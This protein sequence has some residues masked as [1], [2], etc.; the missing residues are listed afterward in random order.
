MG[1]A[2][3]IV[4]I[5]MAALLGGLIAQALKQPL[6]LGYILAGIAVGPYTGGITV[7]DIHN[8][9][10]LAEIGIALLLFALGLEFSF[11]ELRPVRAIALFGTPLQIILTILYGFA[12]GQWLGWSWSAS[13]W[14]GAL[15]SLSSTMVMIKTLE[16]QGMMGTLSSRVMIGVLIVQDL[17]VVPMLIILPQLNNIANGFSILLIAAVK[18]AVFLLTMILIGTK[19]I[20]RLM[21]YIAN[22]NSRELFLITTTTI[23]LGIGYGTYIFGLSFAFGAFVAGILLSESDY[24]YQALSDI[25]PLRD[26]FSLLFFTSIGMLLDINFL[27][28]NWQM[29]V[30][31]VM[32][33]MLGKAVIFAALSRSFGY[34]NVIPLAM[35]L[36]L[37][38]VGEFSFILGRVGVGTK[39]ISAEFYTLVLTMTIVTMFLTPFISGLTTP[40][41]AVARR[42][43]K[44][45]QLE[46]LHFPKSGLKDH[47]VIA[48]GGR[49]GISVANVLRRMNIPFVVLE[50][51]SRRVHEIKECGFPIIFGDAGRRIILDAADLQKAKLL[52]ITTPVAVIS[53]GIVAHAQRIKPDIHIIARAEG[54]EEMKVLYQ[55]GVTYV[56]Q[57]E[58]EASLEIVNQTLLN[59]GIPAEQL[60]ALTE[61]ARQE[62]NKPLCI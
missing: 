1:L 40:L 61:D 30:L 7:S 57:P 13:V 38:Q 41:Y 6:I 20:P 52:L 9:E 10:K 39:S 55:K 2:G 17:A 53:L 56:V 54:I 44:T 4:I 51:N 16:K 12:I 47:I 43:M 45:L 25:V 26:V 50:Y 21:R 32:L 22:W 36:G 48:G 28:N 8:I 37:S 19:V 14:F 58:F 18:A 59:L 33:V 24:G 42:W 46:P 3:D 27:F 29:L 11:R 49:V 23:G 5:V 34:H 15:I 60:K 62:L 31:L 35:G